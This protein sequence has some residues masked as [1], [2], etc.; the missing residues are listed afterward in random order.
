MLRNKQLSF[1]DFSKIFLILIV[2]CFLS[3][4]YLVNERFIYDQVQMIIKGI[5]AAFTGK[6]LPFGNE[7]S[8]LGNLPGSVSSFVIGF[9]LILYNDPY[10]PIYFQIFLRLISVLLFIRALAILFTGKIVVLGTFL[11]ALSPWLMQQ[12][13]LYNPAYMPLGY[14]LLFYCLVKLR[15]CHKYQISGFARIIYSALAVIGIGFCLQLHFSWPALVI[16]CALVWLFKVVRVSY[17]GLFLGAGLVA[18]SLVPYIQEVMVNDYVMHSPDDYSKDRYVGYGFTHVYPVFKG[19][20]YWLRFGSLLFTNKSVIPE[21]ADDADTFVVYLSYAWYGIFIVVGGLSLL[22]AILA[23]YYTFSS[24]PSP[25]NDSTR[26]FTRALALHSCIAVLIVAGLSTITLN[27][28]QIALML[29][30]ALLPIL[31]FLN[32]RQKLI[33]KVALVFTVFTI[34]VHGVSLYSSERFTV[35]TDYQENFYEVCIKAFSLEKCSVYAE[36]LSKEQLA[37]VQSRSQFSEAVYLNIIEGRNKADSEAVALIG[38]EVRQSNERYITLHNLNRNAVD[39]KPDQ[40]KIDNNASFSKEDSLPS[41]QALV[42]SEFV[43]SPES[44]EQDKVTGE[45]K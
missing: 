27:F 30:F 42:D 6:Y 8:S 13:Q 1:G 29:P 11:Y 25:V 45:N 3:Y 18:L 43:R 33:K 16:L 24:R 19:L 4:F 44:P 36:G 2:F 22:F 34:C 21:L 39:V 26:Y 12:A 31:Y 35:K 40:V 23:N 9:P 10:S 7:A 38:Q 15:N 32:E 5:Y 28:W 37:A 14:S 41:D 17:V 20:Y